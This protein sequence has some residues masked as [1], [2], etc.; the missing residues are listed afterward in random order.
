MDWASILAVTDGAAGSDA[1][2]SAAIDLGQR[3]GARVDLLHGANDPRDLLPYVGE[4][5]SGTAL[6]PVMASAEASTIRSR[7]A[8]A[9]SYKRMYTGGGPPRVGPEESL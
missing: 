5:M 1:A 7:K 8:V 3:F 9:T 4:G 6:E 2:M